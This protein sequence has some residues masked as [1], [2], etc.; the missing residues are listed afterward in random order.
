ME[1]ELATLD[2]SS[3]LDSERL[4]EKDPQITELITKIEGLIKSDNLQLV[5]DL[6]GY[7]DFLENP[8]M[9]EAAHKF[10]AAESKLSN[11]AAIAEVFQFSKDFMEERVLEGI[12]TGRFSYWPTLIESYKLTPEFLK[13]ERFQRAVLEF[14]LR[15]M[16]EGS[17]DLVGM[18]RDIGSFEISE[19]LLLNTEYKAEAIEVMKSWLTN[20]KQGAAFVEARYYK[21]LAILFHVE[22]FLKSK[23]IHDTAV[24]HFKFYQ[25][26]WNREEHFVSDE[27]IKSFRETFSISDEEFEKIVTEKSVQ[28]AEGLS[29][30][31]FRRENDKGKDK[32]IYYEFGGFQK[33][34]KSLAEFMQKYPISKETEEYVSNLI[35]SKGT[36]VLNE[37][38]SSHHRRDSWGMRDNHSGFLQYKYLLNLINEVP[39]LRPY[40]ELPQYQEIAQGFLN[41]K[42]PEL[43]KSPYV[44]HNEDLIKDLRKIMSTFALQKP[45][46]SDAV[47][48][49]GGRLTGERGL[50]PQNLEGF[51]NT[52][53]EFA[54]LDQEFISRAAKEAIDNSLNGILDPG[55]YPYEFYGDFRKKMEGIKSM[56]ET[57]P[58]IKSYIIEEVDKI[59]RSI[60]RTPEERWGRGRNDSVKVDGKQLVN[61]VKETIGLSSEFSKE[62]LREDV[63]YPL[64]VFAENR[65]YRGGEYDESDF[66]YTLEGDLKKYGL[67]RGVLI[68]IVEDTCKAYLSEGKS[69]EAE[70]LAQAFGILAESLGE[71]NLEEIHQAK[72]NRVIKLLSENLDSALIFIE[73]N[74]EIVPLLKQKEDIQE[75]VKTEIIKLLN[76]SQ[77]D[78]ALKVANYFINNETTPVN[79]LEADEHIKLFFDQLSE[80]YPQL[81]EKYLNSFTSLFNV[82][83]EIGKFKEG[84]QL[85]LD[86]PF[87]ATALENNEKYGIKLLL[88]FGSLDKL[89]KANIETLYD[90]RSA[91]LNERPDI[92]LDSRDFRIAVQNRLES[93]RRNAEI[94]ETLQKRGIY[95]EE[96]LNHEDEVYFELGREASLKFSE[97]IVTP[98][99][100]IQET[101]DQ[102][103]QVIKEILMEYKD[104][105]TDFKV[106]L[107]NIEE[108]EQELEKLRHQK[109]LAEEGGDT[110]KAEGVTKGI[111]SI[112][113]QIENP[114]QTSLWDKV[115]G[116]ITR[117]DLVKKDI[118]KAY[119][120]LKESEAKV[121]ELE[122]NGTISQVQ[123]RKEFQKLKSKVEASKNEMKEKVHMLGSRLS[124][125]DQN[126]ASLVE[127]AIGDYR[128]EALA[129][130]KDQRLGEIWDHYKTD[131]QTLQDIFFEKD[132]DNTLD[133]QPMRISVWDRNPDTDLYLGNYTD[134]CIRIDSQHMGE[135]STIADYLTDVG[136][137]IVNVY[138][139]KKKMPIA[140]AWCWV[141]HDDD[142]QTAFVID[143]IEANT[144]YST[145]YKTQLEVKLKAYIED[146][147]KKV[148]AK[149]VQGKSNNDLVVAEMD[150]SYYK[151]GGYNRASGYYLEAEGK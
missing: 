149:V 139:E 97:T 52:I 37:E 116:N 62:L 11:Q 38:I 20:S 82:W 24:G 28:K 146:Y 40:V 9:Q 59:V 132:D 84:F 2:D 95:V 81:S 14:R 92:D 34:V 129:Q 117:I 44:V 29:V 89:S 72:I 127:P 3:S 142:D 122:N 17:T 125:F 68:D 151:L 48:Q 49:G 143:N 150:S 135:E 134:C 112:E 41:R 4:V 53:G 123:K 87:L 10:F 73:S 66:M 21:E 39:Q 26:G 114:K 57:Y 36:E 124:E 147:A 51:L 108:L 138:D 30:Y 58:L 77:V 25:G 128:S 80:K 86:K 94:L 76:G 130:E 61:I 15:Q 75:G 23:E 74:P 136:M 102:Y 119:A 5:R 16:N 107:K 55:R 42:I 104:K 115:S 85:L 22:E 27:D 105:L 83:P 91:I 65:G 69:V 100:R 145:K 118:F 109:Q 35:L 137:Q 6:K 96:W 131:A 33:G 111:A 99:E 1:S 60:D 56:L 90:Y 47:P 70:R 133:G 64:H 121:E 110:K 98:T 120:K 126:F 8:E 43:V 54:V 19:G 93:Y 71:T 113:S 31:E 12:N 32:H 13:S 78:K 103:I 7:P 67:E 79:I 141:G 101:I 148:G 50:D 45:Q 88:K 18:K 106:P 46:I 63:S 144:A 140:S